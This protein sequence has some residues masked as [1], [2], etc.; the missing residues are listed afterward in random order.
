M[1]H[2]P[3]NSGDSMPKRF[4]LPA[5]QI[6]PMANGHG[7]CFATDMIVVDGLK[8]GYMYREKPHHDSDSGWVFMAGLESQEYVDNPDNLGLY[9]VNEVLV[10]GLRLGGINNL[11]L[12]RTTDYAFRHFI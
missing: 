11:L 1:T 4:F 7:A 9:D 5:E 12:R 2:A 3:D 8:V 6:K 10:I